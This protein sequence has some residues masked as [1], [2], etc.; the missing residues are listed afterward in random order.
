MKIKNENVNVKVVEPTSTKTCKKCRE[1][2]VKAEV[3]EGTSKLKSGTIV[4]YCY[5]CG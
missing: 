5:K 4:H 1:F 2:L 3:V